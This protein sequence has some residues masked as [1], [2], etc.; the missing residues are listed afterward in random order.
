MNEN[1]YEVGQLVE[2]TPGGQYQYNTEFVILTQISTI[3]TRSKYS[4]WICYLQE[5]GTYDHISE[6]FFN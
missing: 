4:I 1:K 3:S 6:Y 5:L 2:L